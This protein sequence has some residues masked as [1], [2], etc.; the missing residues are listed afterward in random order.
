MS[1]A[2]TIADT[3]VRQDA[4]GRF[5]LNDLHRAAGGEKRHQPSDWLRLQ[6]TQELV[7][8]LAAQAIPG[9]PGI[10]SKQGLGTFAAKELVYAYAMWISAAFHLK[11]IRAYDAMVSKPAGLN[12]ANL[13]RIELLQLAMQAEQERLVL[14]QR[15]DVLEPKAKAL[16]RF[17]TGTDGSFCLTDAA[18]SLQVQPR[19]FFSRLQELHWIH[20]R[21]MGTG[22]LAYQDRIS[23]GVLEHKVTTGERSDGSEWASTQVRVT[24]KGMAKLSEIFVN[25]HVPA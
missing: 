15:V 7:A 23:Q 12:A 5:S 13:T 24:A 14:E 8:E 25:D 21:P 16:D 10:E 17:A 18:K 2:L 6:Q 20:R 1:A 19:R 22:W 9:I 4:E 11:V 3:A